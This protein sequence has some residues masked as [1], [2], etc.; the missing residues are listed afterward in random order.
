MNW[1]TDFFCYVFDLC[2]RYRVPLPFSSFG[3]RNVCSSLEEWLRLS[4]ASGLDSSAQSCLAQGPVGMGIKPQTLLGHH[5]I[6]LMPQN[7]LW[8]WLRL[9]GSAILRLSSL[10]NLTSALPLLEMLIFITV[11]QTPGEPV[12]SVGFSHSNSSS[13][14]QCFVSFSYSQS[15]TALTFSCLM[16]LSTSDPLGPR[17][18]VGILW[19][20]V[21]G[22]LGKS[23]LGHIRKGR[24]WGS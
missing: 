16:T 10:H 11:H 12:S 3:G 15:Y 6:A 19:H 9:C 21:P 20:T 2:G 23:S 13:E 22:Q 5:R 18:A 7:S 1:E 17:P 8:G 14:I 4:A 24:Q